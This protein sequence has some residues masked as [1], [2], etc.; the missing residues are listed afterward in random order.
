VATPAH[1]LGNSRLGDVDTKFQ[2]L[3]MNT[4]RA[5]ERVIAADFADQ[6][7]YL[8]GDRRSAETTS[9]LPAPV[10]TEAAS[11]PTYQRLGLEDDRGPEQRRK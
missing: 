4:R 5:P 11:M 6:I 8:G 2:Q 10:E 3:A 1:V 7:A 9:R